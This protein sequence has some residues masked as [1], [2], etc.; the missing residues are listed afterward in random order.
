MT[1]NVSTVTESSGRTLFPSVPSPE[2]DLMVIADYMESYYYSRLRY[3]YDNIL[4][5][6][7]P[8]EVRKLMLKLWLGYLISGRLKYAARGESFL[9][10]NKIA[11]GLTRVAAKII[12][13]VL[14]GVVSLFKGIPAFQVLYKKMK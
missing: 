2:K 3:A 7:V 10:E 4:K 12:F 6:D 11:G 5:R 9:L 1:G 14:R 8:Y 13:A